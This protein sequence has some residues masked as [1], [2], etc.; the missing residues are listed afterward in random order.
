MINNVE[1]QIKALRKQGLSLRKIGTEVGLSH[2]KVRKLLGGASPDVPHKC[3]SCG[4]KYTARPQKVLCND[5]QKQTLKDNCSCGNSKYKTA[6]L[7]REC[8][9]V[10]NG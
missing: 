6:S 7:C 8:Y 9:C 2:E 5:C 10:L 4:A 3:N 1:S